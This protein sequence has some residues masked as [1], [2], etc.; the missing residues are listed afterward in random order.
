MYLHFIVQKNNA[1]HLEGF[2]VFS[3]PK[4]T[5]DA[6]TELFKGSALGSDKEGYVLRTSMYMQELYICYISY[7]CSH[8]EK[9][10]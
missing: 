2:S 3:R 4:Q 5:I 1:C 7:I 9:N 10:F 8:C 6:D